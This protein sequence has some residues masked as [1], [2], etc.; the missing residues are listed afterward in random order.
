ML[1]ISLNK[2]QLAA[3]VQFGSI[4]RFRSAFSNAYH[5]SAEGQK[6]VVMAKDTRK[7]VVTDCPSYGSFFE[8]FVKGCH[9]RMGELTK[10]DKAISLEILMEIMTTLEQDWNSDGITDAMRMEVALEGA[11]YL[12]SY[13]AGLRGEEVPLT[14]LH[15]VKEHFEAS[16]MHARPHVIVAL[17]GRFKSEVGLNYH[18]MAL[19][20]VTKSGLEPRKWIGRVLDEY[21]KLGITH[22]PMFRNGYGQRIKAS[23]MDPKF[24]GRLNFVLVNKPHLMPGIEDVEDE[25]GIHRSFRRGVTSRAVDM[26]LPTDVIEANNRWRKFNNSGASRPSLSMKEHYTDVAL[27]LNQ[28]LRFSENL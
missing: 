3:H 24:F 13:C 5:A 7:L 23:A 14:D 26:G 25:Y 28:R 9:K 21:A 2:G 22:G 8:R 12:I 19:V 11:F 10:P 1:D 20:S 18:L 16:G 6:A 4:R 27:T 15:G 17:I